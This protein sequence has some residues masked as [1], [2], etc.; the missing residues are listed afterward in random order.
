M[1]LAD[2]RVYSKRL[3]KVIKK[4]L[5]KKQLEILEIALDFINNNKDYRF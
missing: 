5:K 3:E 2:P 4:T 1:M